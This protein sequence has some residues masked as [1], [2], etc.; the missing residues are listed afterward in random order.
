MPDNIDSQFFQDAI[1]VMDRFT[2]MQID[3]E[4][5]KGE[6]AFDFLSKPRAIQIE[7]DSERHYGLI[8]CEPLAASSP[9][10]ESQL[11]AMELNQ[12]FESPDKDRDWASCE[13]EVRHET[14]S[15]RITI[16]I[17][18]DEPRKLLYGRD[19]Q[20]DH[21]LFLWTLKVPMVLIHLQ[22]AA[23]RGSLRTAP[24]AETIPRRV[25]RIKRAVPKAFLNNT[26]RA[27]AHFRQWSAAYS[28]VW[29]FF[30]EVRAERG[31]S[32]PLWHESCF[33]PSAAGGEFLWGKVDPKQPPEGYQMYVGMHAEVLAGL[34]AW[35]WSK[36]IFEFDETLL[37]ALLN[38]EVTD[39]L[40][41]DTLN[42]LPAWCIYVATPNQYA[43]TQRR[44]PLHGFFAFLDHN[45]ETDERNICLLL[46][47]DDWEYGPKLEPNTFPLGQTIFETLV[48][49]EQR[50]G[51]E[52]EPDFLQKIADEELEDLAQF[53][54]VLLY[55][56]TEKPDL[57]RKTPT[58]KSPIR[59][60][61]PPAEPT[62]WYTG[63][64]FGAAL[65]K[66]KENLD[67]PGANGLKASS[68]HTVIPHVRRAHYHHFY[69]G[70]RDTQVREAVLHWLPPILVNWD[71]EPD[72]LPAVIR[73]V[74]S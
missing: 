65:R 3:D 54:S 8:R 49:H 23:K 73:P 27:L 19:I 70:P 48:E 13:I 29:T 10:L 33:V 34:A 53:V 51:D 1:F 74:R 44:N 18:R 64:R 38:T 41:I 69:R 59:H 67:D 11:R 12:T 2:F 20:H 16:L 52:F 25:L 47:I 31:E 45:I 14:Q 40:P 50:F 30:D 57:T 4:I 9:E 63:F 58:P 42:T 6:L 55:L 56:R 5:P 28:D 17:C 26:P 7:D 46:D 21:P 15:L 36:Y 37:E 24:T 62:T 68:G 72:M 32:L 22:V 61:K 43:E 39:N 71:G 35:R 66:A 60:D